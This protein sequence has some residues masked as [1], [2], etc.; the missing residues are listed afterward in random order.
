M[1]T[2]FF[3]TSALV[4]RYRAQEPGAHRVQELFSA[5][6]RNL[7]VLNLA[8]VETLQAFYRL[9][10][11]GEISAAERTVLVD[12][13]Y[14]DPDAHVTIYSVTTDHMFRAER[15]MEASLLLPILKKQPGVIDVLHLC[16][17]LDFR[18]EPLVFVSSDRDLSHLARHEKLRILNP[19][20]SA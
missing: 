14:R 2:Y 11:L 6:E 18:E 16:A 7:V 9:H 10:Q 8:I 20:E 4:K 5:A 1:V 17:A 3:D 15:L 12:S 19:E 13:F